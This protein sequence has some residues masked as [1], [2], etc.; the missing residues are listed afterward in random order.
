MGYDGLDFV[1]HLVELVIIL[2]DTSFGINEKIAL[3]KRKISENQYLIIINA[4]YSCLQKLTYNDQEELFGNN[5]LIKYLKK[6]INPRT[7]KLFTVTN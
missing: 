2:E 5:M 1:Y 4:I 3:V 6:H 7:I